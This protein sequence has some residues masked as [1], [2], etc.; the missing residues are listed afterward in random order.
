[1]LAQ[2]I[3]AMAPSTPSTRDSHVRRALY[4]SASLLAV[5]MTIVPI[6]ATL[7]IYLTRRLGPSAYG[8]YATV[9]AV[10]VWIEFAIVSFLNRAIITFVA[11]AR[12]P[13]DTAAA[14][15]RLAAMMGCLSAG[16]MWLCGPLIANGLGD[17]LLAPLFALASID[18]ALFVTGS[19]YAAAITGLGRFGRRAL[20]MSF[21]WPLRLG[22]SVLLVE[23]GYGAEGALWA[24]IGA[25][26]GEIVAGALCCPLP[27]WRG[28][29]VPRRVFLGEAMPLLGAAMVLRALDGGDLLMLR[30]FG[31]AA[32]ESGAYAVAMN[33]AM[34]PGMG[35]AAVCPILMA[36]MVQLRVAGRELQMRQFGSTVIRLGVW[37]LPPAAAVCV[38]SPAIVSFCFGRSYAPSARLFQVLLWAGLA[39]LA[40]SAAGAM[41]AGAHSSIW[42]WR[43]SAPMLPLALIGYVTLIPQFGAIGAAGATALASLAGVALSVQALRRR[44]DVRLSSSTII[45]A[46]LSSVAVAALG[47]LW[48]FD[49]VGAFIYVFGAAAFSFAAAWLDASRAS[50]SAGRASSIATDA[51]V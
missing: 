31:A 34:L 33:L 5:Q 48:P 17:A 1:L 50:M 45:A 23:A 22:L 32:A 36:S 20:A 44:L 24:V 16:L 15:V 39:R 7:L 13:V 8:Q 28:A 10:L 25:S 9:M 51:N 43:V 18:V 14:M 35:A 6:G 3:V 26:I 49:G 47:R 30:A 38:A 41:L 37:L 2:V 11:H 4:G 42:A 21:R 40:I 12:T 27:I 46:C 29:P 19:A